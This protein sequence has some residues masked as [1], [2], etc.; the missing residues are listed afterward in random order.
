MTTARTARTRRLAA[1]TLVAL[2]TPALSGCLVN[3][4]QATTLEYAPADGVQAD[5]ETIDVRDLLVVSQGDGAPAV[6]SGSVINQSAEPV[7]LTV[8]VAGEALTPEVTV[9]PESSARLDG[10]APDGTAGERLVVPALDA[11]AGQHVDVRITGGGDTLAASA[12][13][14]LP[15]GPYADYADDAGGTVEPP[16]EHSEGEGDH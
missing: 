6:V 3:S 5:G 7:T 8:T 15:Q 11:T 9:E 2:A 13:V 1:L 12:P 14:L 4:P 10:M 16:A